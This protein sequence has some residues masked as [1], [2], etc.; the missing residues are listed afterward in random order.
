M[1]AHPVYIR[2]TAGFKGNAYSNSDLKLLLKNQ[3]HI[4]ARRFSRLT[5]LALAGCLPLRERITD[6]E[7]SVYAG[8]AFSSPSIFA[9]MTENVLRHQIAKPFDFLANLHNA[10][11]FHTAAAFELSGTT[12]LEAVGLAAESW[13]KPLLLAALH[14]QQT[15]R[16]ALAGWCHEAEIGN[17][18]VCEGSYWL[19]LSSQSH[20]MKAPQ[21]R[22]TTN[23]SSN[24]DTPPDPDFLQNVF[25]AFQPIDSAGC[26]ISLPSGGCTVLEIHR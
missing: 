4:D 3:Y 10:P 15:G 22:I 5:L 8:A 17:N 1:T 18:A 13:S 14:V 20:N 26:N 9:S 11:V 12:L 19:H 2:K 7:T 16:D 25:N 6:A 24:P 23:P 21:I